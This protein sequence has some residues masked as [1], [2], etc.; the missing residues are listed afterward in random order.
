MT[1]PDDNQISRLLALKRYERMPE[2]FEDQLIHQLHL[3]QRTEL[4]NQSVRSIILERLREYWEMLTGPRLAMAATAAVVI[5]FV[6]VQLLRVNKDTGNGSS[7]AIAKLSDQPLPPGFEMLP[8]DLT[9]ASA[10]FGS[11]LPPD[12][13]SKLS[14]LLLSKH[15]EGSYG[16]ELRDSFNA[17][18]VGPP[19]SRRFTVGPMFKFAEDEDTGGSSQTSPN[20]GR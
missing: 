5:A 12:E 7:V 13:S 9:T 15:F 18:F 20:G 16:D 4:M 19:V 11:T 14:P 1:E 2:G 10:N 17:E 8:P 6:A 3:R